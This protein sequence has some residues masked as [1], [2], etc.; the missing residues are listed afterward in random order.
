MKSNGSESPERWLLNYTFKPKDA[1]KLKELDE[2][3][4]W[5]AHRDPMGGFV[6]PV[7]NTGD[8]KL[9][10]CESYEVDDSDPN[11]KK[12]RMVLVHIDD[13]N[14]ARPDGVS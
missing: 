7:N 13:P 14:R 8:M 6:Y 3:M 2:F 1:D 10:Y 9:V 12:R 11:L 4:A 5:P